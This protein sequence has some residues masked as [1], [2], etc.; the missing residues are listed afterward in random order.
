MFET[1]GLKIFKHILMK[2][3]EGKVRA[4]VNGPSPIKQGKRFM[5][6]KEVT[7]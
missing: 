5:K 6:G 7:L 2:V 4:F 1:K 3:Y